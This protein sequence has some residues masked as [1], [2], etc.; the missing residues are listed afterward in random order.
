MPAFGQ[1][2]GEIASRLP[3]VF[4]PSLYSSLILLPLAVFLTLYVIRD[5]GQSERPV[6]ANMRAACFIA[7]AILHMVSI[8][9]WQEEQFLLFIAVTALMLACLVALYFTYPK[10][11]NHIAGRI[12]ISGILSYYVFSLLV[13]IHYTLEANDWGGLGLS[14]ALWAILTLTLAGAAALHFLYHHHDEMY[15]VVFAWMSLMVAARNGLDEPLVSAAAL[16]LAGAVVAWM[17]IARRR[18]ETAPRTAED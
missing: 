8:I 11:E 14:D 6:T 18:S 7:A 2:A 15:A 5:G 10:K 12:P 16:F 4:M 3:V 1:P 9:A 17:I 13:A